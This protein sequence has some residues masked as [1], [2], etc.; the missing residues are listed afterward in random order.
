MYAHIGFLHLKV[1]V[2]KIEQKKKITCNPGT[3]IS[4]L[5]WK[6][7]S[8]TYFMFIYLSLDTKIPCLIFKEQMFTLLIR[9]LLKI[10]V[11]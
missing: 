11:G 9:L 1:H 7:F 10:L 8:Q 5:E 3:Q 4:I 6:T 2:S